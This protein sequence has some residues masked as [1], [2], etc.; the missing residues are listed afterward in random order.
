MADLD[1]RLVGIEAAVLLR[2][3]ETAGVSS[4]FGHHSPIREF[5]LNEGRAAVRAL[6]RLRHNIPA[7]A[8]PSLACR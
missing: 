6:W 4:G 8:G 2:G 7:L 1:G 3:G 5:C